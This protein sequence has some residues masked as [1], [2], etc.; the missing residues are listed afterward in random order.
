MVNAKL[1]CRLC[2]LVFFIIFA[3]RI[4]LKELRKFKVYF[5]Y[6]FKTNS[7]IPNFF[8]QQRET[9]HFGA[10]PNGIWEIDMF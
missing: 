6:L 5:F 10:I 1:S 7:K 4:Q 8:D 3:N 2:L 9:S